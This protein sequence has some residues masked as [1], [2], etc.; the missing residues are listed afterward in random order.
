M[1]PTAARI[2]FSETTLTHYTGFYATVL[3]DVF[4][5]EECLELISSATAHSPWTPAGLSAE[6][7][8]QTVHSSFR[9]SDRILYVDAAVSQ[10]IYER[11]RPLVEGDIGEIKV[12]SRWDGVTGKMRRKQGP[13]WRLVGVNPRLSFLRYGPGHYFKQHCDGLN[14]L[15]CDN[16]NVHKSFVTLHLYLNGSDRPFSDSNDSNS[17]TPSPSTNLKFVKLAQDDTDDPLAGG[18]TRFW[19]PDK[20]YFLDVLPRVGRVLVFQQ[21]MLV[22]SGEEV[23]AGVKYTMRSDFMFEQV[24]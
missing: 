14:D 23:T 21:R 24:S 17:N 6:G 19:T 22:H 16:G 11:L 20:K 1:P 7:P 12:G 5:P 13:S 15:V 18:A 9:N 4:T 2:N 8:T 3:D 10:R